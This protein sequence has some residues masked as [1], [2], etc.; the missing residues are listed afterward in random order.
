MV[1]FHAIKTNGHYV[2]GKSFTLLDYP[3]GI[4]VYLDALPYY[5]MLLI[6]MTLNYTLLTYLK[7]ITIC[8]CIQVSPKWERM[9]KYF[10][11]VDHTKVDL[12]L[13]LKLLRKIHIKRPRDEG[14][15]V[16]LSDYEEVQIC[17]GMIF[18]E[19]GGMFEQR[20]S[21]V[22]FMLHENIPSGDQR[23]AFEKTGY[24]VRKIL[25]STNVA[26][27]S[28]TIDDIVHV[29]DTGRIQSKPQSLCATSSSTEFK[30]GWISQVAANQRKCRAGAGAGK[31][32][33]CYRLYPSS[34]LNP[35]SQDCMQILY[36]IQVQKD[37]LLELRLV[38]DR[39]T[40]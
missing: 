40:L 10:T 17:K 16:F 32:G 29:I 19:D 11:S 25:L 38:E 24:S 3:Y 30:T 14:I 39:F 26:E 36:E 31:Y 34:K 22:V 2:Y 8:L 37:S 23:S 18:S 7:D 21:F 9:R 33:V 13:V 27:T 1:S 4:K 6:S 20:D 35:T 5:Y 15:L 28:I 12:R